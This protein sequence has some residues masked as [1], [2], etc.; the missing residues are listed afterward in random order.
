V[1]VDHEGV[2]CRLPGM[3]NAFLNDDI[4]GYLQHLR[5]RMKALGADPIYLLHNLLNAFRQLRS[6]Q[7]SRSSCASW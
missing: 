5:E 1:I 7:P 4:P 6:R 3:T 2:T